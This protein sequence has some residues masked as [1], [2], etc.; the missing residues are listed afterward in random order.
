MDLKRR[1]ILH[2]KLRVACQP[3]GPYGG[4]EVPAVPGRG[5]VLH[6]VHSLHSDVYEYSTCVQY[7]SIVHDKSHLH[8]HI[9]EAGGGL[10]VCKNRC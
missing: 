2:D 3:L 9:D 10:S 1:N 4:A 5:R 6:I 8:G 7:M